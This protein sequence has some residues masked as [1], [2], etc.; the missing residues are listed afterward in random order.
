[1]G[2][3]PEDVIEET[4]SSILSSDSSD[5]VESVEETAV[6][7]D[8]TFQRMQTIIDELLSAISN[9]LR[10]IEPSFNSR[11]QAVV[12]SISKEIAGAGLGVFGTRAVKIVSDELESSFSIEGLFSSVFQAIEKTRAT[13]E[14]VMVNMRRVA[15]HNVGFST[16]G[17]EARLLQMHT[18]LTES[19][20][21]L[22]ASRDD[23]RKW[24]GRSTE[25][26]E[27]LRQREDLLNTSSEEM[28]RMHATIKKLK[29]QLLER[30]STI[31][32]LRGDLSKAESQAKQQVELM[33]ALDSNEQLAS[34]YD[35]KITELSTM[36]GKLASQN[37]QL[38]QKDDELAR[39]R[40]E[41][42]SFREEKAASE[43]RIRA[44]IDE[45]A[46]LK[47]SERDVDAE[48]A[49]MSSEIAELKTR[50]ETLYRVAEDDTTFKAYFLI[51]DKTQ[52]F[53][54][55]HLSSALGIPTVLLTRN[56]Q[57]F[58]DAG[59]LEIDGD[60]VRPRSLSDLAA[61]ARQTEEELL[62][63]ARIEVQ[64]SDEPQPEGLPT[65][66]GPAQDDD[67][68]QEGR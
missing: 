28:V 53:Q 6:K 36:E 62:E 19:E 42:E 34:K 52:W 31:S 45:L 21:Q 44:L 39:L 23:I 59:L 40:S 9:A 20:K 51:A 25:F 11:R 54:L 8:D 43:P 12:S 15:A 55:S 49:Q 16:T 22:E 14:Q 66:S 3:E 13:V 65:Y 63:A 27:R 18:K 38:Q 37:E 5:T 61:E 57:K 64:S 50:W 47:G 32:S 10:A 30:E 58:V 35:A 4:M 60:R 26:E 41:L 1:M 2:S 46:T 48:V 56:L 7:I 29:E 67:Y 33:A 68:K 17:L 24:R